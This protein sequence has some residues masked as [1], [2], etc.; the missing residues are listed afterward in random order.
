MWTQW[1]VELT[2]I[3]PRSFI[4]LSYFFGVT[5]YILYL[6]L[7]IYCI[8]RCE[9]SF[10][11]Q[12]PKKAC[13]TLIH[14][15]ERK[16][17]FWPFPIVDFEYR[18]IVHITIRK[19]FRYLMPLIKLLDILFKLFREQNVMLFCIYFDERNKLLELHG[20]FSHLQEGWTLTTLSVCKM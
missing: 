7:C 8:P 14:R 6:L 2:S 3:L 19:N 17:F 10:Q 13:D 4:M 18:Y 9:K 11:Q 1:K 16:L 5:Y 15:T 12:Q 20:S